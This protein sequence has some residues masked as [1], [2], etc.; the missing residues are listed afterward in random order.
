[1]I[2]HGDQRQNAPPIGQKADAAP[3][4]LMDG[5][6]QFQGRVHSPSSCTQRWFGKTE[7]LAIDQP[8][9]PTPAPGLQN[10]NGQPLTIEGGGDGTADRWSERAASE[11]AH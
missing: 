8:A 6:R 9:D 1:M 2:R 7:R 3:P 5:H 4:L 10:L 11:A